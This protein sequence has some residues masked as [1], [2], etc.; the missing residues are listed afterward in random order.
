MSTR[1]LRDAALSVTK[2]F[3]AASANHNTPT[4]DLGAALDAVLERIELE[5][6]LP[7]LANNI[8]T[9]HGITAKFQDSADNSSYADITTLA[10]VSLAGVTT[11]GSV[12]KTT[13]VKLPSHTRRYVQ[14]NLAASSGAGNNTAASATLALL[15]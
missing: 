6:V 3:P 7:A 4:I 11:S 13:V 9:A 8:D 2:A 12:L 15:L 14:A 1:L 10:T 5:L